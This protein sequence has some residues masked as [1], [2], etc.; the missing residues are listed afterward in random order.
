MRKKLNR[1]S[2]IKVKVVTKLPKTG[3]WLPVKIAAY[4]TGYSSVTI[5]KLF[6]NKIIG[7]IKFPNSVILVNYQDILDKWAR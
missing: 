7:S 3:I 1:N 2:K 5:Y 4:L 6:N